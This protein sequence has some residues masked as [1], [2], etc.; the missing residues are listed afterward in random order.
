[1]YI[2]LIIFLI[3]IFKSSPLVLI[4]SRFPSLTYNSAYDNTYI[5]INPRSNNTINLFK[6]PSFK[7]LERTA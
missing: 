7:V 3:N 2:Y 4:I 6:K 5:R 1:M